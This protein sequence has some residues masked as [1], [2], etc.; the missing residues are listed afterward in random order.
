MTRTS[1]GEPISY[2]Y[3]R[4]VLGIFQTAAEVAGHATQ[5]GAGV[6]RF[7]YEDINN[8]GVINDN[9]RTKIGDP[10]PDLI[11]GVNLN[12]AY[13]A[14][15]M[16]MFWNGSMGND[17]F[18]YTALYY[19]TPYFFNGGRSTA[20]LDS[21]SPTNTGAALPALSETILNNEFTSA[22]SFFVR[23]GSYL[24]LRTLQNR[25]YIT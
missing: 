8:D 24:R 14:W 20:V 7:K 12:L 13:K 16:S 22:N 19:E 2:F 3:G 18:D 25:L 1:V 23:D 21:W 6:G 4:N 5:D 10:H 9:D 15:D 11:F 17:I